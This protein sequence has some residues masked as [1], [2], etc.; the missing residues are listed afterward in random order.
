MGFQT[1]VN[2]IPAPAQAGDFAS[3]NPRASV[4]AGPGSLIT[5]TGGVTVGRF[6]WAAPASG[7]DVLSGTTQGLSLVTNAGAGVPTGFV[8]R[9]QQALITVFLGETSN[10]V[11]AGIPITLHQA[12]DFWAQTLTTATIGQKVFASNTDGTVKT[13][14]ALATIA[15]YTETKW[16]VGSVGAVNELIKITT[17]ANG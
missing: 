8:H 13:G 5:G 16:L 2:I 7:A 14:A 4:L 9:E 10:L 3:A 17:W 1:T 15:G 12:G 6:A 11:P